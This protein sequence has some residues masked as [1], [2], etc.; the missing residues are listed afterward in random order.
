MKS[1]G[2]CGKQMEDN[3]VY[4]PECGEANSTK[5]TNGDRT[6]EGNVSTLA[7]EEPKKKLQPLP[8]L[9]GQPTYSAEPV[10]T[11][12]VDV[13]VNTEARPELKAKLQSD[14]YGTQPQATPYGT[15]AQANPYAV[16]D[17]TYYN[18][19]S[20]VVTEQK[21]MNVVLGTI[22]AILGFV[23]ALAIWYFCTN[24]LHVIIY[25]HGFVF[26]FLPY[27]GYRLLGRRSNVVVAAVISIV[28]L[29]LVYPTE[30]IFGTLSVKDQLEDKHYYLDL[31]YEEA[32][33]LYEMAREENSSFNAEIIWNFIIIYL[34]VAVGIFSMISAEKKQR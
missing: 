22:G 21:S 16:Q 7:G 15:Q 4:C 3:M 29:L 27:F 20:A 23:I 6:T 28:A 10:Y 30:I 34:G 33:D 18:T 19:G 5:V 12:T 14:A 2:F 11:P 17:P 26:V 31:T 9:A 1:C 32:S 24:I 25:L 8:P 13:K